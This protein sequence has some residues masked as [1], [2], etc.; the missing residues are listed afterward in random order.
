MTDLRNLSG[1]AAVRSI[2]RHLVSR[3]LG[4][5]NHELRPA[6][7]RLIGKVFDAIESGEDLQALGIVL[8]QCAAHVDDVLVEISLGLEAKAV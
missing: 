4:D 5:P 3:R 2:T 8:S 1:R 6:T 7:H